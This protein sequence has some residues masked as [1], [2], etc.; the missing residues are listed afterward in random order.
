MNKIKAFFDN[1]AFCWDNAEDDM[2]KVNA[3]LDEL[4]IKNGDMV[5]DVACG[6][7]IITPLLHD[8]SHK[9][10]LAI[11]L[12]DEMIKGAKS[13]YKGNNDL[14]FISGDFIEAGFEDQFDYIVIYNAY[15]HF[16]NVE[17]LS[18][19]AAKALKKNGH[20][21]IVHSIG[22]DEL[23]THHKQHAMG[24]SRPLEAADKEAKK[25]EAQFGIE[26]CLDKSDSYLIV[27]KKSN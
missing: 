20:L 13:K 5:L 9:R 1:I 6:K 26:K 21:A 27:L 8:R 17:A 12:S 19:V 16:M 18:M 22:K 7:G 3:L 4:N 11:D 24:V 15:P 23:N 14:E 25:F 10:V 2:T